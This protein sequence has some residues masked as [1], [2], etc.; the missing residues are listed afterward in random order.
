MKQI[1]KPRGFICECRGKVF[2]QKNKSSFC[3]RKLQ[4]SKKDKKIIQ[5]QRMEVRGCF[6]QYIKIK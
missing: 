4:K 5:K 6:V 2:K 3:F 1:Y